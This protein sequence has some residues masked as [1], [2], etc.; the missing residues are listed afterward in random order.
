[1]VAGFSDRERRAGE[2]DVAVDTWPVG[3]VKDHRIVQ[4]GPHC[5]GLTTIEAPNALAES[6]IG[7]SSESI[8]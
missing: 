3:S 1:M 2:L 7:Y 6:V 5:C 8:S 4:S